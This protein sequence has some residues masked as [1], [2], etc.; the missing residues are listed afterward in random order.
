MWIS[1]LH[2][3]HADYPMTDPVPL[4]RAPQ[5]IGAP[6]E[7]RLPKRMADHGNMVVWVNKAGAQ[8]D[9]LCSFKSKKSALLGPRSQPEVP[10]RIGSK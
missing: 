7:H 5:N 4:K 1:K 3:H 9:L 8:Y 6:T 2:W 10:E